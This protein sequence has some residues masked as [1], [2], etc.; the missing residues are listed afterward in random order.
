VVC[1]ECGLTLEL[2]RESGRVG[3]SNCYEVF[4]EV[5]D[6]LLRRVH[7]ATEHSPPKGGQ[8]AESRLRRVLATLRRELLEAVRREEFER[9]ASLRDEIRR[10]EEESRGLDSASGAGSGNPRPED[11]DDASEGER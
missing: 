9:A 10:Y 6:P 5:L 3:C 4:R 1:R 7:H 11:R 8:D 2:F